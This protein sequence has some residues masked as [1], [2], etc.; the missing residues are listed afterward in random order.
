MSDWGRQVLEIGKGHDMPE[1]PSLPGLSIKRVEAYGLES[2]K[3]SVSR[4]SGV[5]YRKRIAFPAMNS[6]VS[7]A[8]TATSF[9]PNVVM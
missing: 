5:C 1:I 4:T 8:E 3:S 6:T 2:I 9:R 7:L